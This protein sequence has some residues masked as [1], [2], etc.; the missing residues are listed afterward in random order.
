MSASTSSVPA[1]AAGTEEVLETPL[2]DG[3]VAPAPYGHVP[4]L[5]TFRGNPTRTYYGAGPVP[6][7][8]S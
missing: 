7:S 5:L 1:A 2:G 8:P 6:T 3:W 4:G